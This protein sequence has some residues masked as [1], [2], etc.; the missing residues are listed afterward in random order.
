[1]TSLV[2]VLR[3]LQ[4]KERKRAENRRY[5]QKLQRDPHRLQRLKQQQKEYRESRHRKMSSTGQR[6]RDTGTPPM[7]NEPES[8]E[9]GTQ[10][11]TSNASSD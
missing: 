1:M 7:T 5:Y 6:T 11:V 8:V 9:H 10:N 2:S 3:V 4:A